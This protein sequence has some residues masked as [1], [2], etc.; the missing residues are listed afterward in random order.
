MLFPSK[1]FRCYV[2]VDDS[3][4]IFV[5]RSHRA[6][7]MSTL[8][9]KFPMFEMGHP[10]WEGLV[11][12]MDRYRMHEAGYDGAKFYDEKKLMEGEDV[13]WCCEYTKRAFV[14][15]WNKV[16]KMVKWWHVIDEN[17]AKPGAVEMYDTSLG[18]R[19]KY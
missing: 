18:F 13:H 3:L 2:L 9:T 4:T 16:E 8:K 14:K 6:Q 7:T 19:R 10:H 11:E 15:A 17:N 1:L 12:V 5:S